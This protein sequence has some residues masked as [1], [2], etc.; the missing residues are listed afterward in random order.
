M[1]QNMK[2]YLEN[3]IELEKN[4]YT[5]RETIKQLDYKINRLGYYSNIRRSEVRSNNEWLVRG[6]SVGWV[7]T[8]GL[9]IIL[10]IKGLLDDFIS[11]AFNGIKTGGLIGICIGLVAIFVSYAIQKG[12]DAAQQAEWDA[13]YNSKV[14]ADK[15]RVQEEEKKKEKLICLR[16]QLQ[17]QNDK[18]EKTLNQ[19]YSV[20]GIYKKYQNFAAVCS[21]YEYFMSG[22]CTQ[23]TGHEG[24][25]NK[26]D[27][28]LFYR[29]VL[30]KLDD[31]I[32]NLEQI[33]H[34]QY[35]LYSA[36][37]DGNR[38]IDVL[39]SESLR[40]TELSSFTAE[41]S[42]IAAYSASEARSELNQLKWLKTYELVSQRPNTN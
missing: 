8:I 27:Q 1:D 24:A 28:D 30:D 10:G 2:I 4:A 37:N 29:I 21:F 5:Q 6:L 18:T 16:N 12:K 42:A 26:Y 23:F 11:G 9:A 40:Q 13:Q 36:I 22:I 19:Y 39:V 33:K 15:R 35:Q 3:V 31:I 38:K 20:G 41:Q 17:K 25:Y 32:S 34:H 7:A 14:E